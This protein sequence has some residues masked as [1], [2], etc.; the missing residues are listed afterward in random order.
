MILNE[1]SLIIGPLLPY[2]GTL[3][4]L[5][6]A[7]TEQLEI[8]SKLLSAA[9]NESLRLDKYRERLDREL[10]ERALS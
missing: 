9:A 8:A 3:V 5:P 6:S 4:A 7:Q 1:L 10:V 2:A